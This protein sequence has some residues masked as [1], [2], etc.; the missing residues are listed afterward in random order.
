MS[1]LD[2]LNQCVML[3]EDFIQWFIIIWFFHW[4]VIYHKVFN[5][6]TNRFILWCLNVCQWLC[7]GILLIFVFHIDVSKIFLRRWFLLWYE[8]L[9]FILWF[10]FLLLLNFLL[11]FY[12]L[13]RSWFNYF[14]IGARNNINTFIEV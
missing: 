4:D 9:N 12:F 10:N 1:S 13:N 8:N 3:R 14:L 6:N 7:W 11:C 2:Y 5:F